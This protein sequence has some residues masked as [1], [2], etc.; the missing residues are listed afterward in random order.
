[1]MRYIY[2]VS[3]VAA[4]A[5][6]LLPGAARA[7][8][9]TP[10]GVAGDQFYN[11]SY[12]L[13]QYCNG[14]VWINMG[15]GGS[16]SAIGTL[17]SG[18]WCTSDGT[19]I[20]CQ[21]DP[22]ANAAGSGGQVQYNDGAG[23]LAGASGLT[24]AT[25][26]DIVT[27]TALAATDVG[28]IVK[29][30]ISQSGN[31]AEFRDSDDVVLALITAAGVFN[32]S[33]AGLSALNASNIST[34]TVGTARLGSGTADTTTFLRGDNT[35]ATVQGGSGSIGDFNGPAS[36]T[37]N[38]VIRFDGTTGKLAQNSGVIISDANA[39][40]GIATLNTTGNVGIGTTATSN[41]LDVYKSGT[42]AAGIMVRS[43]TST[44]SL[45]IQANMSS[46]SHNPITATG[47]AII[48][49][50][51]G[52]QGTGG[53]V[54]APWNS[55]IGGIRMDSTGSVGV[56]TKTVDASAQFEMVSTS[57]GF[58]P[59]RMDGTAR[60]AISSPATGL[61]IYNTSTG[62]MNVYAG[63]WTEVGSSTFA[64]GTVSAP[65]W[66]VTGD[67]N[68][69]LYAPAA[70]TVAIA[71]GGVM[72]AK[73][74]ADGVVFPSATGG[75]GA[76]GSGG[77][78]AGSTTDNAVA[79]FD[80]TDSVTQDS[81]VIIDDSDNVTGIGTLAASGNFAINTNKFTVAAASGNTVVAG[82][83]GVTGAVTGASFSGTG[84][85]LTALNATQ[86]TSGT[87]PVARLASSGT[88]D[89]STFLRG[90]GTWA[91]PVGSMVGPGSSTDNAI[92]RWDGTTGGLT[93]NS[94][95][96]IDDSGNVTATS[97]AGSGA[98]LTALNASN[99]AS[100][101]VGTARLGS[102]TASSSTYLRGDGTWTTPS[103]SAGMAVGSSTITGGNN[104]YV[105]YDNSGV[106][107]EY[108]ITGTGNVVMSASPTLTGTITAAAGTF[109][110]TVTANNGIL[111]ANAK[112]LD[113]KDS[114]GTTRA[115]LQLYSDDITYLEG[116]AGGLKIRS[117][118]AAVTAMTIDASGNIGIGTTGPA[119]K[120]HIYDATDSTI[121]VS[122]AGTPATISYWTYNSGTVLFGTAGGD[123]VALVTA[124]TA[125]MTVSQSGAF[126]GIGNAPNT[127]YS[128]AT[129][130]NILSTGY[131]HS[132]DARLKHDVTGFGRD[133]IETVKGLRAVHFKWNKDNSEDFG[134]I[135]QEVEKVLPEAITRDEKGFMAVQYD[136]LVLPVIEAV[137]QMAGNLTALTGR[138]DAHD[139]QMAAMAQRLAALEAANE[140]LRAENATLRD[141]MKRG[142]LDGRAVKARFDRTAN[143]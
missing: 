76:G 93:Q 89:S 119:D 79:R 26:T 52:S 136:K 115:L 113:S 133:A 97:F 125:R 39:V 12:D 23:D 9:T 141:A 124:G 2:K 20:N 100:G 40:T 18:K 7:D 28:L 70:D 128:L 38:A 102:G 14:S 73:F 35:W 103:V 65:G 21:E 33:G 77:G 5:A 101:T 4:F 36:S 96:T 64:A 68:T 80:G 88:A 67:A 56:G 54:I 13:M 107:G 32:G 82:T 122:R 15:S 94:G 106:V 118:Y 57:K 140:N 24:Y 66:A 110:G 6:L 109:S 41:L 104:G 83:L 58:L 43:D 37:D 91:T 47:D 45:A 49:Y 138:V 95:A 27:V 120:L 105:L 50:N 42:T 139:A 75:P 60:D 29:G 116:G 135:A 123:A 69:G 53:L 61:M 3:L 81:G 71:A 85:S 142:A 137:K 127:S 59:P 1:M 19:L 16:D 44:T 72:A 22:P 55:S 92:V 134:V 90:D 108:A 129:A 51:A 84:T 74:G 98:S 17:E 112:R 86:L 78:G 121:T 34:G 25:D 99:L 63:G 143:P 117:N 111:L 8:C 87:V 130:G 48:T 30:A 114:G 46:G 10:T 131:Y 11:T 132:S 31:L 62:K 126:V